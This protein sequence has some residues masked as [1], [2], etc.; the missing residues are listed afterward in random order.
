[1]ADNLAITPGTGASVATD[2]VGSDHYQKVKLVDGTADSST[3]IAAGGG[4]ETNALRVT[5]AN[6]STGVVSVDDN[7]ASL[8]VDAA[9]D[10]AHD[11]VDSGNPLKVGGKA[12]NMDGTEPGTAVAENDRAN[13]LTDTYGRQ[14]VETVHP[15]FGRYTA[16]YAAAQTNQELVAAPAAGY[17]IYITDVILSTDTAMNIKLVE[18]TGSA[19]DILECMYFAANGGMVSNFKTPLKLTANKNLGITSSDAG[20]HSVVISY[21]VAP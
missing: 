5:L 15:R 18:D 8:T 21:Y 11:A 6:N 16:N 4:T 9:G 14:L 12:V 3:V 20:N 10:L 2:E 19:T 13:M 1:M 7:S 17:S